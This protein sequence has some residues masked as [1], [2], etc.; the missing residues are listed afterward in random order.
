[1][2]AKK[3]YKLGAFRHGRRALVALPLSLGLN[4]DRLTYRLAALLAKN[5]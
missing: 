3:F 4:P 1:M 2:Y 5:L